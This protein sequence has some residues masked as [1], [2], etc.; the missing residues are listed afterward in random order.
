MLALFRA[1]RVVHAAIGANDANVVIALLFAT[2]HQPTQLPAVESRFKNEGFSLAKRFNLHTYD[3]EGSSIGENMARKGSVKRMNSASEPELPML[4]GEPA[5]DR[6]RRSQDHFTT[7]TELIRQE[8]DDETQLVEERW[9]TW[10]KQRLLT[11][12]V[13]LFDLKA[14]TQGRFFGED[15]VVFEAQDRGRLPDHRFSHGDIVLI[16]RSRPWGE[17]VVEG[18]VLDRGPTRL[19][20]VVGERPRDV[21]KGGWR[22]DRGANR[23]AHDRMHQALTA[24]HSTEGDGGTVLRELLLGNVLDINQSAELS[25]DIR[26]K[27]QLRGPRPSPSNLN[28]SQQAA[29]ESALSQR[30]T[31]IQGPPGTGKTTTATHLLH[32]FAQQGSGPLLATAESNVAVD[33]LLEGLLDL[34]VKALRIGRPVKV[35][36]HLRSATLDAL[37][38]NHPMQEEL[39]FLQDEQRELRRSLP[40]LKGKEKGLMHRDISINQKEIRRMENVMTA[41]VLDEA[42]VICATTIGCGH[43]LLESRK[44]PI[45]LMDEATQATEPSALVPI[46]KGCRQLVLVGDHQQLPPTVLSRRAEKGGLNRSLFD[47]LIACGLRSNLLTTQYRMHPILREFPS[48]RFYENRLEDGCTA[49]QRPPPAGFL[50][51]DWDRPMAFVPVE[52]V[53]EADEE[54]KSRSN[55]DEAAKVLGVVNDLLAIGDLQPHDIGVISPY[56]G[57]VR[58]LTRLFEMAGGREPGQPYA[59]LEIKSVDGYQGREKE[60]IVFSTVRANDRGEV[61]FLADYRRLNVAITRAKR[62]LILLGHP[63]TLRHDGTWRSYLDWVEEHQLFAWHVTHSS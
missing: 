34:G 38:E 48:A 1:E 21:R 37:L 43:R 58:E 25:P 45:V 39:A 16:S 32:H 5:P 10:S 53:E 9:K 23:V 33:N 15:I 3:D 11:A 40:S 24:F 31:L 50:W 2:E 7:M 30:L 57:Q 14:R 4:K 8:L 36:E 22:L 61:G 47:R 52:G 41:S 55:R 51:P 35:R 26:G 42:E 46:V 59:G 27:R 62:G 28:A 19:R 60:V 6:W 54:G 29:I 18:V 17:K 56:N 20:V 44:F 63:T 49:D 13:S 12:G